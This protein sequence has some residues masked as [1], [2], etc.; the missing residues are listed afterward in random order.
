MTKVTIKN[1]ER[2]IEKQI[3]SRRISEQEAKSKLRQLN[4][5]FEN[6]NLH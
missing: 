5:G 3:K 4:L 6:F 1:E 2:E